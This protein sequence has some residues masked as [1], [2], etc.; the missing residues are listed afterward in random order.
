MISIIN[1]GSGNISALKSSFK[2][3]NIPVEEIS[4]PYNLNN[5]THLI[6]PGVGSFKTSMDLLNSSGFI[7]PLTEQVILKEKKI[8]GICV[9]LQIM[10]LE[11]EEA[12]SKKG[13]GWINAST[14]KVADE[15]KKRKIILPHMGWNSIKAKKDCPLLKGLDYKEFYFLHSY[16]LKPNIISSVSSESYY[17]KQFPSSFSEGNIYGTQF[18]PEKSH[19]QGL[20]I[21]NNFANL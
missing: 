14:I 20:A 6:L 1:Y 4:N 12:P 17:G 5:T 10:S 18:H 7:Q 15:E 11:S 8:L 2:Q 16:I 13:L 3:L 21:L 19:S 9:G